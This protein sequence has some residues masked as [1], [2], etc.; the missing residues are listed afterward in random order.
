MKKIINKNKKRNVLILLLV[1]SIFVTV[2][3][4]V[5]QARTQNIK[6][7]A[8]IDFRVWYLSSEKTGY[9]LLPGSTQYDK[10]S[11]TI[12]FKLQNKNNNVLTFS[13]QATPESNVVSSEVFDTQL[14]SLPQVTKFDSVNGSVAI[15]KP[16]NGGQSTAI[17]R[18]KGTIV[19]IYSKD[20]IQTEDWRILFND[21]ELIQ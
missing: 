18:S 8:D 3:L 19:Y 5:T 4:M 12:L 6:L 16:T 21:L 17:M 1:M 15:T 20:Q 14:A 2:G 9:T 11:K 13:Q 7:P 10:S